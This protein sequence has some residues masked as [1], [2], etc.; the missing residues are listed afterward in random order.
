MLSLTRIIS[1]AARWSGNRVPFGWLPIQPAPP[2]ITSWVI[3]RGSSQASR[4]ASKASIAASRIGV[5]IELAA[6]RG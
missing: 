6:G 3:G 4:P 5:L 2:P 1:V